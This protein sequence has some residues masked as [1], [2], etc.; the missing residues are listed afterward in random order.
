MVTQR[1]IGW[2]ICF[3]STPRSHETVRI[4]PGQ[5][6]IG[7]WATRDIVSVGIPLPNQYI[8]SCVLLLVLRAT[9]NT[10]GANARGGTLFFSSFEPGTIHCGQTECLGTSTGPTSRPAMEVV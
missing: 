3:D 2:K 8:H 9:M 10:D 5:L 6:A 7:A 4:P 1:M